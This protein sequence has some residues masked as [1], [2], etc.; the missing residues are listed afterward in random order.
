MLIKMKLSKSVLEGTVNYIFA[1]KDADMP[2]KVKYLK[3]WVTFG[4]LI[5]KIST[6]APLHFFHLH[7]HTFNIKQKQV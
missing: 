4:Q 7:C 3:F 1:P 2:K 5:V 6:I